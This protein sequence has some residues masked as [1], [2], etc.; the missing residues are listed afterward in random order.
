MKRI[1]TIKEIFDKDIWG[2]VCKIKGYNEWCVN[3]GQMSMEEEIE[4]SEKEWE[5]LQFEEEVV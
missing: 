5:I 1:L 4:F 3:E 2:E